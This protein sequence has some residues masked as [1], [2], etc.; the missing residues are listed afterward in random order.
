MPALSRG[1]RLP[2]EEERD[3]DTIA[4]GGVSVVHLLQYLTVHIEPAMPNLLALGV[5]SLRWRTQLVGND[6]VHLAIEEQSHRHKALLL[7]DPSPEV[8]LVVLPAVV[9][10]FPARVPLVQRHIAVPYPMG[11]FT[12]ELAE[13]TPQGI[14]GKL[15]PVRPMGRLNRLKRAV[16]IPL[17]LPAFT[18]RV[19]PLARAFVLLGKLSILVVLETPLARLLD[20]TPLEASRA[21][22]AVGLL[23]NL[24]VVLPISPNKQ[25]C[26]QNDE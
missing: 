8:K 19:P 23:L 2:L 24:V 5:V 21:V 7:K 4:V 26:L 18:L 11:V 20:L 16:L 6:A 1:R 3:A 12:G 14:V 10:P 17:I 22:V 13:T 9:L 15:Y 25:E